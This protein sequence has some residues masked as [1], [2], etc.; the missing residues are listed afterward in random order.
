M[1]RLTSNL[2]MHYHWQNLSAERRPGAWPLSG[3]CWFHVR[4]RTFGFEWSCGWALRLG[5]ETAEQGREL[6]VYVAP[7]IASLFLT[8]PCPRGI[9][10]LLPLH[11]YRPQSGNETSWPEDRE[12]S[13]SVHGGALWWSLWRE[14]MGGWDRS[15]PRWRDGSFNPMDFLLGRERCSTVKGELVAVVVPMPEGSYAGTITREDRVWKRPRWPL[16]R[17]RTDYWLEIPGGGI[18]FE[19][20]GENSW[21][22]G[23]D[24]LCG[25]GGSTPEVAVSN[26]VA[27]VLKKRA[28]YGTPREIREAEVR[29]A[30]AVESA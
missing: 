12:I 14:P 4:E 18:P 30:P 23:T 5:I 21:D 26:A 7:L 29:M 11:H 27:S 28:R 9:R 3:R 15:V 17:R 20:K 6:T 2:G 19:G 13:V 24:G 8:V 22:C 16:S 10:R 1:R 25:I